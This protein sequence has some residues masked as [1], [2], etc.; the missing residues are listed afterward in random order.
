[1]FTLFYLLLDRRVV[2]GKEIKRQA[3]ASLGAIN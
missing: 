1:M 3:A 2:N